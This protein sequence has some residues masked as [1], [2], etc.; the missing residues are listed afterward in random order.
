MSTLPPSPAVSRLVK[1]TL[2]TPFHIDYTWWDKQDMD[3]NVKLRS[4]LCPEHR[5][6]Y[7]NLDAHET[8]DWI[9]WST[10]KV[11]PVEGLR[12]IITTHCSKQPHYIKAAATLVEMIFRAFLSNDNHPMTPRELSAL[13]DRSPE[14]ILRVLSGRQVRNGL[15]PVF[16]S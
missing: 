15:R 14:Q 12:Y 6:I 13:V 3:L 1:P 11:Y 9:E 16:E 2:D 4:H 7:A 8:I 10:G 5:A